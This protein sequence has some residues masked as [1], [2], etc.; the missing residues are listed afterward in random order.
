MNGNVPKQ[1]TEQGKKAALCILASQ[2]PPALRSSA[3]PWLVGAPVILL[4]MLSAV[5]YFDMLHSI[6]VLSLTILLTGAIFAVVWQIS[7]RWDQDVQDIVYLVEESRIELTLLKEEMGKYLQQLDQKTARHFNSVT[8]NK[9]ATY[10]TLI[11]IKNALEER[12]S[13]VS[14]LI[15]HGTN[16]A[17]LSCYKCLQQPLRFSSSVLCSH[18]DRSIPIADVEQ[19]VG[20]LI[21]QLEITIAELEEERSVSSHYFEGDDFTPS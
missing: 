15:A 18:G 16:T 4:I 14:K 9:V 3:A 11:Q 21:E 2:D 1:Q 13:L 12:L 8:P 17:L 20:E 7:S 10:F 19:A 5:A 6:A